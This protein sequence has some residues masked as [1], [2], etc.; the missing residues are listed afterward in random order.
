MAFDDRLV[1]FTVVVSDRPGGT[2]E[3][4]HLVAS[5]GASIKDIFLDRTFHRH[6]VFSVRIKVIVETKGKEH[7]EELESLVKKRYDEVDFRKYGWQNGE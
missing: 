7:V 6:G 3:L 5:T 2:A 4:T 1:R